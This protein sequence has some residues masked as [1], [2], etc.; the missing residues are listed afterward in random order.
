MLP[1]QSWIIISKT[2]ARG[3]NKDP[4][5]L[6]TPRACALCH[7]SDGKLC[8]RIREQH[9][10]GFHKLHISKAFLDYLRGLRERTC[11]E[12]VVHSTLFTGHGRCACGGDAVVTVT[13]PTHVHAYNLVTYR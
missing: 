12:I 3:G 9:V 8:R 13:R 7:A 6:G 5:I 2:L 11:R 10:V 4:V 1:V